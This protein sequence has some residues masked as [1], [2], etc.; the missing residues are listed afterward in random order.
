MCI[1]CDS[2]IGNNGY[3]KLQGLIYLVCVDCPKLTSVPNIQGLKYLDCYNCPLLTSIPDL[4]VLKYLDCSNCPK[5]TT[6]FQ[7]SK[8]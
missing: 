4:K 3:K 5:L 7:T 8:D 1:V 2:K 6:V